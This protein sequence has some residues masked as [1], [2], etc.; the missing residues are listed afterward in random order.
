MASIHGLSYIPN[1]RKATPPSREKNL[2]K[3]EGVYG[4]I[5]SR[6]P[7]S[8][9]VAQN[10]YPQQGKLP[11]GGLEGTQRSLSK[12]NQLPSEMSHLETRPRTTHIINNEPERQVALG[13]MSQG[14]RLLKRRHHPR[15]TMQEIR[16]PLRQ[17]ITN[18]RA[19]GTAQQSSSLSPNNHFAWYL[20]LEKRQQLGTPTPLPRSLRRLQL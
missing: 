16:P 8:I 17:I 4:V 14:M 20:Q 7:N 6:P 5:H 12:C 15:P 9:T 19:M 1:I 10:R 18:H 11:L 13:G 2:H 3:H